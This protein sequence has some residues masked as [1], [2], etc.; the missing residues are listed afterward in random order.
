MTKLANDYNISLVDAAKYLGV[1]VKTLMVYHHKDKE[2]VE[3][4]AKI[5]SRNQKKEEGWVTADPSIVATTTPDTPKEKK[6]SNGATLSPKHEVVCVTLSPIKGG[7]PCAVR[8]VGCSPPPG[9]R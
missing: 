2:R 1:Q 5:L 9:V 4:A 3:K 6:A 7:V 8:K